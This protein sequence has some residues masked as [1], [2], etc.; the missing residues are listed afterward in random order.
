MPLSIRNFCRFS[1]QA[2]ILIF[3]ICMIAAPSVYAAKDGRPFWT[4]K[5]AF[6]EG[7]DLYVVGVASKAKNAEEGRRQAFEQG[8]IELMNYA[9]VTSLEAQGL[10]IETQMTFEEANPDNTINVFRLLRV[11]AAKLVAIQGRLQA[12]SK[13][14]EQTLEQSR[15]ELLGIQQS[16]AQKQ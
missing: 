15:K 14:Q 12:Q 7:E 2:N 9:Q 10:V 8:K 5:S 3:A 4:E 11:P 13:L 1:V 16:L 6:I